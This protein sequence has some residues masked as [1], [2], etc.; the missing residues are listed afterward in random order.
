M[1]RPFEVLA[2]GWRSYAAFLVTLVAGTCLS[3]LVFVTLRHKEYRTILSEFQQQA[4]LWQKPFEKGLDDTLRHLESLADFYAASR[5]VD[6]E[7]FERFT[8]RPLQMGKGLRFLAWAPV[9]RGSEW[10]THLQTVQREL[11]VPKTLRLRDAQGRPR[12]PPDGWCCPLEYVEPADLRDKYQ[13]VDLLAL[14]GV[15]ELL[16]KAAGHG[17][18][19]AATM[20]RVRLDDPEP[21]PW[22]VFLPIYRKG[23][24]KGELGWDAVE[25]FAVAGVDLQAIAEEAFDTVPLSYV[26]VELWQRA[27]SGQTLHLVCRRTSG[28]AASAGLSLTSTLQKA[29]LEMQ[30]RFRA[31]ERFSE[32]RGSLQPWLGLALGLAL[33][34]LGAGW[35]FFAVG[36]AHRIRHLIE[37]RTRELRESQQLLHG[38]VNNSPAVIYVKGPDGTYRFVNRRFSELFGWSEEEVRGKTDRDLF[39]ADIAAKFQENDREVFRAGRA[40]EYEETAPHSDG[41]HTYISVKFPIVD[42]AGSAVA[43]CGISTDITQRARAEQAVRDSEALYHSLVECLPLCVL[44]K[45][46]EGRFTF[47]NQK[48]CQLL[49]RRLEEILGRT[50]YDFFP[51]ELADKYRRDDQWVLSS[52]GIF[53]DIEAHHT[54]DGQDLYVQVLKSPVYD[55]R[56]QIVGVQCMFWDVTDRKRAE[57]ELKQARQAAEAANRAKSEFLARVSHEIR[58]P[59]NAIIGMTDLVLDSTLTADQRENLLVVKKS[60]EALLA[61]INDLL[62]FSKIEAGRM[63]LEEVPFALRQVIEESLHT[64]ALTASQKGLRLWSH[65]HPDVPAWLKGDPLRLRQVL[66]NLLSNAVKFTERGEVAL[67]VEGGPNENAGDAYVLHFQVRDT[68][69]GIPP[70]KHRAIF[71]AF[72]QAD[73]STTRRYGGTG[74]GL[75]IAARLVELMGGRIWVESEPGQGSV[76]HFTAQLRPSEAP[77]DDAGILQE[78][79]PPRR[80]LRIL[81]AEDSPT[82]Q[83]LVVSLLHKRGHVVVVAG[84]G[85]EAVAAVSRQPFDVILMDLQ[86]PDMDGLDATRAIRKLEEGSGRHTPIIALTAHALKG[87]KERCLQAGMDG[88]LAKPLRAVELYRAVESSAIPPSQETQILHLPAWQQDFMLPVALERVGGDLQLLREVVQ[89]FL[90]ELPEVLSQV[91][92]A[93][94]R[95]DLTSL[96]GAAHRLKGSLDALGAK[97]AWELALHLEQACRAHAQQDPAA[98]VQRLEEALQRLKSTLEQFVVHVENP[99]AFCRRTGS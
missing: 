15:A 75:T 9:V 90:E 34:L 4:T 96:A 1:V 21:F 95:R 46:R 23:A 33:T 78:L 74:L 38:I 62:D 22:V 2:K 19:W 10:S 51:K 68:G 81:L 41:P 71:E 94:A 49:G 11:K 84:T 3:S 26:H 37:R 54:P 69:V 65:V 30:L 29:G 35:L 77:A 5:E 64:V 28:D 14:E 92:Q 36:R 76:F 16:H 39:P 56:G 31:D 86:M 27:P 57:E 85:A 73:G 25:G 40:I 45:D 59:M 58:T 12:Q 50:D 83:K 20:Q 67:T 52:G 18:P 44:R 43:L 89:A 82:N 87:D 79:P 13:G 70:E 61:I 66:V 91:H 99:Q 47:G 93:L 80:T 88:Y 17:H 48:F 6:A 24:P 42:E 8:A 55:A 7:E 98:L 60:A 32:H 72:T 97:P 53:E 63:H